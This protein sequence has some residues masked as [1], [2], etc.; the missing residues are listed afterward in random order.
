MQ[1]LYQ[2]YLGTT[3]E[4][5]RELG[6][7]AYEKGV[8]LVKGGESDQEGQ[9]AV[10]KEAAEDVA[11]QAYMHAILKALAKAGAGEIIREA[12]RDF[13]RRM[14]GLVDEANQMFEEAVEAADEEAD[15]PKKRSIRV[16]RRRGEAAD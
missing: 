16:K 4:P 1:I 10:W 6:D 3:Y 8:P 7:F 11:K 12:Q 13:E 15:K 5:P 2:K 14:D 9:M